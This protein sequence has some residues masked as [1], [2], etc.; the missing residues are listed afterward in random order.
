MTLRPGSVPWLLRHELRLGWRRYRVGSRK[1]SIGLIL[2]AV[3]VVA[4]LA[5]IGMAALL[6]ATFPTLADQLALLNVILLAATG[7]ML[8]QAL[9]VAM[10]ALFERQDL[11]W[12]MASPVPLR[13]VLV[14]RMLG[15]AATV[16]AMWLLI[17][18]ATANALAL[19]GDAGWLA[20]YPVVGAMALVVAAAGA[21][22]AVG[23]VAR[24]GLTRARRAVGTVGLVIGGVTFLASQSAALLSPDLKSSL[25]QALSPP[26]CGVPSGAGWWPARALMGDPA[27]LAA[28][29]LAALL[30]ASGAAW[31]L[32]RHFAAGAALDPPR[33]VAAVDDA[34][35][36]LD[37]RRFR[38]GRFGALLRK[39]LRLLQRTPNLVGQVVFQ[40][41]YMVPGAVGLWRDGGQSAA[42]GLATILVF[43]A[44]EATRLLISETAGADKAA[45][46]AGTAPVRRRA[47]VGAKMAA[48]GL[49][50]VALTALP[51]LVVG[52][53]QPEVVPA[54]LAGL[55]C[56]TVAGMLLGLWRPIVS[57]R[58]D[59]GGRQA[60]LGI[61]GVMA[62][63]TSVCWTGATWLAMTGSAWAAVPAGVALAVLA[64]AR[65]TAT[66]YSGSL[67]QFRKNKT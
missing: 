39:E 15:I 40:V 4:Q 41:V 18:G 64:G 57:R 56:V 67:A 21:A 35:R 10:A 28:V 63:V 25:W 42:L 8:S 6:P 62:L 31:A 58:G 44:G 9:D 51:V 13:R 34:G 50:I 30:V 7:L 37:A 59:L 33:H 12:L 52:T 20:A 36:G 53:A 43:V 11:D 48:A 61:N 45:D 54:L 22:L 49:G 47:V 26:C 5:G 55:A 65:P 14:V 3:A 66:P 46:L 17:L 27:P 60:G 16:A 2:G 19:M 24:L 29:L 23:L 38:R 32:A 1:L